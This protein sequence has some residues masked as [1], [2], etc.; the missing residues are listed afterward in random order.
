MGCEHCKQVAR[1]DRQARL[2]ADELAS[3]RS[4][5]RDRLSEEERLTLE[6][7]EQLLAILLER[8]AAERLTHA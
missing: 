1:I 2:V 5:K 4:I 8:I 3:W 7:E 6:A